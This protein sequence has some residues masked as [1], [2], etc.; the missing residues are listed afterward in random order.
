ML[1]KDKE[2]DNFFNSLPKINFDKSIVA[3]EH[4]N[5][6]IT[7]N[8]SMVTKNFEMSF[9]KSGFCPPNYPQNQTLIKRLR[10]ELQEE[11]VLAEF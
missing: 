10:K 8:Q 5:F 11:N 7:N 3:E 1:L 4:L 9:Q 6:A 2:L